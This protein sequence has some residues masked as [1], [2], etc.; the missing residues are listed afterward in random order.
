[1]DRLRHFVPAEALCPLLADQA[2]VVWYC[3][4]CDK[5]VRFLLD[6]IANLERDVNEVK[7]HVDKLDARLSALEGASTEEVGETSEQARRKHNLIIK[8]VPPM[9]RRKDSNRT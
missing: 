4:S 5:I 6:K 1:M 2:G 8:N 9:T 3:K 7:E